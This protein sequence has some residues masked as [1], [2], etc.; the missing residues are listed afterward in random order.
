M[1]CSSDSLDEGIN[2]LMMQY[3]ACVIAD[4]SD[5]LP[6]F[7]SQ[8][9]TNA[10]TTKAKIRNIIAGDEVSLDYL[11]DEMGGEYD[12]N[13]ILWEGIITSSVP[14]L[15]WCSEE[16]V[17]PENSSIEKALRACLKR[18]DVCILKEI[19]EESG[20]WSIYLEDK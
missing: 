12:L 2:E 7:I 3:L 18:L 14:L 1:S 16:C 11:T 6:D 19:C 20:N 13:D 10:L 17:Y 9:V 5:F 15:I 8:E 4:E